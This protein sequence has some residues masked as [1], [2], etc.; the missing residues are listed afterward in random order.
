M[1]MGVE[2]VEARAGR[3]RD[4]VARAGYGEGLA[5]GAGVL[6][7]VVAANVMQK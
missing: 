1:R 4:S 6:R 2:R 5:K 3:G 7:A